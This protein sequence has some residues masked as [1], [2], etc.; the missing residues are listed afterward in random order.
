MAEVAGLEAEGEATQEESLSGTGDEEGH[1]GRKRHRPRGKT[2]G[3]GRRSHDNREARIQERM[4]T[5]QG[6]DSNSGQ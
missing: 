2:S 3:I 4:S 6:G 1:R 5:A